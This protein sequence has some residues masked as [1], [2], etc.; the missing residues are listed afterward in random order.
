MRY[1][2]PVRALASSPSSSCLYELLGVTRDASTKEVKNGYR[3]VAKQYHPDRL[4]ATA[5][6]AET[7]HARGMFEA[8]TNA[9]VIL[10]NP[11]HRAVYD[12]YG[13]GA[14]STSLTSW[15]DSNHYEGDKKPF[16]KIAG[17]SWGRLLVMQG[18][19]SVCVLYVQADTRGQRQRG[20]LA[21]QH[22][23]YRAHTTEDI[24]RHLERSRNQRAER[25]ALE[26]AP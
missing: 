8:A 7:S 13:P 11:Q 16:W 9:H 20:E 4:T 10:T 24:D 3:R 12:K 17:K 18:I 1:T 21:G 19:I 5:T 15:R 22:D 6:E 2:R 26:K 23:G 25:V 14:A